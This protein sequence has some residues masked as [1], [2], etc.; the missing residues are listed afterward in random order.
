MVTYGTSKQITF[1]LDY[2]HTTRYYE[3]NRSSSDSRIRLFSGNDSVF[4][5]YDTI[6]Y[7]ENAANFSVVRR[8]IDFNWLTN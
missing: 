5:I 8:F 4:E 7:D 6:R 1:N 2:D 3:F